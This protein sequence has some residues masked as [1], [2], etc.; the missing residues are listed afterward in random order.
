MAC[1]FNFRSKR[2]K[3]GFIIEIGSLEDSKKRLKLV[4]AFKNQG[5]NIGKKAYRPESKYTRVHSIY[6][7]ISDIDDQDEIQKLMNELWQKSKPKIDTATN[8]TTLL[9]IT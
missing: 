5:F 1:W 6:R 2:A 3:I 8:P 9:K 4:N 7:G